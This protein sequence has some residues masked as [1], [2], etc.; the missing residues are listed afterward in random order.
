MLYLEEAWRVLFANKVRSLL[1][2][3]GLVIGT[4]AVIAIQVLGASMAGAVNGALGSL[5]DN[6]F[7]IFPDARQRNVTNSA[8]HLS[9]ISAVAS[10]VPG[11]IDSTPLGGTSELVRAGH[12]TARYAVSPDTV[13]SLVNLPLEYGRKFT[14]GD[15]STAANVMVISHDAYKRLYPAGGDPTGTSIYAGAYRYVVIGVLTAPKRGFINVQFDGDLLIPWTTYARQFLSGSTVDGAG[16]VVDDANRLSEIEVAT[17]AK[18]RELHGNAAGISYQTGDKAQ[19]TK[20]INNI[21]GALTVIVGLIGL[22]SL[23]VAGIGIMNI[24]LVSVAERTREIGIRKA[25]GARRNQILW[26]FFLEAALLCG[27]GCMSGLAIGLSLGAFVNAFFIVKLTGT[28]TPVPWLQAGVIAVS[29]AAFVTFAFGTYPAL[30]AASLD[31]IE[32]LRYE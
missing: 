18:L 19:L 4:S 21:F 5:T 17:I 12:Q 15:L 2:I 16:F 24:M 14:T 23:V 20:G 31:P 22:V 13:N 3:T 27:T 29:F 6:S 8:I 32:A 26:Q 1:T 10:S 11:V 28:V 30:R 9:D 7:V 25:I